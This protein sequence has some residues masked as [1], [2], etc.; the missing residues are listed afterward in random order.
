MTLA[1][2]RTAD[3]ISDADALFKLGLLPMPFPTA[4]TLNATAHLDSLAVP[5]VANASSTIFVQMVTR[6]S[7][8]FFG[9]V[10]DLVLRLTYSKDV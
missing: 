2:D 5:F 8:T 1:T 3:S 6:S 10:G 7:H 9:A 4:Q